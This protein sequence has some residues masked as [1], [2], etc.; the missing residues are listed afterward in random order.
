MTVV[1]YVCHTGAEFVFEGKPGVGMRR[2][3]IL[4]W[5]YSVQELGGTV[6]CVYR[7]P[8]TFEGEFFIGPDKGVTASER[9]VKLTNL[10]SRDNGANMAGTFYVD[11]AF[12]PVRTLGLGKEYSEEDRVFDC[13]GIFRSDSPRW[14]R[15]RKFQFSPRKDAKGMDYPHDHPHDYSPSWFSG[16]VRNTSPLPCA[17]RICVEGPAQG[18]HVRIADNVYSCKKS[19]DAGEF[20]LIDGLAEKIWFTDKLGNVSNAFE[21][22]DGTF[23]DGSGSF[24]FQRAPVGESPISWDGCDAVSITLCEESDEWM[25]G[26]VL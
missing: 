14:M 4:D 19:L 26:S 24:V 13:K 20:L 1:K 10:M 15:E 17:V 25:W 9:L 12:I 16:A 23:K 11:D 6:E 8:R 3:E 21:T 2:G 7:G 22:W 5:D 18:W